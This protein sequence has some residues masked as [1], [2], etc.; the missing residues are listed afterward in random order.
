MTRLPEQEYP[1]FKYWLWDMKMESTSTPESPE[2]LPPPGQFCFFS[3]EANS[4][5]RQVK[6]DYWKSAPS[7]RHPG[8]IC[9]QRRHDK[10][11]LSLQ[12]GGSCSA[13]RAPHPQRSA[14]L[15]PQASLSRVFP[16]AAF[17]QDLRWIEWN[18]L[19]GNSE[20]VLPTHTFDSF[21]TSAGQHTIA[22]NNGT[23]TLYKPRNACVQEGPYC[24]LILLRDI[25][26]GKNMAVK[27]QSVFVDCNWHW[28]S[29]EVHRFVLKFKWRDGK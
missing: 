7:G 17:V 22:C 4:F 18:K 29:Y 20:D 24:T 19:S 9:N 13:P 3:V 21:L 26:K 14:P 23:H 11:F 16:S 10:C 5:S 6:E 1:L 27:I 25:M 2:S 15:H 8:D 28:M 12:K